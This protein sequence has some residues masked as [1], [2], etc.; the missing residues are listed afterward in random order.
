MSAF[1]E[2][3]IQGNVDPPL[4]LEETVMDEERRKERNKED[5]E[6]IKKDA[7]KNKDTEENKRKQEAEN[8]PGTL[9]DASG[10]AHLKNAEEPININEARIFPER[11][12]PNVKVWSNPE[13]ANDSAVPRKSNVEFDRN[14]D[15]HVQ[16]N[17]MD[18][19]QLSRE[20]SVI[21]STFADVRSIFSTDDTETRHPKKKLKH[22]TP[23][24]PTHP[25]VLIEQLEIKAI[26]YIIVTCFFSYILG[27]FEYGL[28]SGLIMISFCA[29]TYWNLGKTSSKGLEW[30]L[31][32]QANMK[33][34]INNDCYQK[35]LNVFL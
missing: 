5:V 33:I 15:N 14:N 25:E 34:V 29:W 2:P 35:N 3:D 20:N 18:N 30:Q 19:R 12:D 10:G 21:E 8:K 26:K 16:P 31:E 17:T 13:Y 28:I 32:K 27:R 9:L 4:E 22:A 11:G 24:H 6:L 7:S 23:L 1:E